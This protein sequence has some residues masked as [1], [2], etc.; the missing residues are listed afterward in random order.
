MKKF[1]LALQ[2]LTILSIRINLKIKEQDFGQSL[3]YFPIVGFLIGLVLAA[4]AACLRF[5]PDLVTGACVLISSIIITGGIHLDGFADTCDGLYGRR[6]QEE[7]LKIMRDSRAGV[8]GV[9][10][11]T[12]LLLLKFTLIVSIPQDFLGK[13]LILMATFSRWSQGLAC[14]VSKYARSEGK[15]KFFIEYARKKDVIIGGLFTLVLFLLMAKVNGVLIFASAILCAS[16]FIQYAKR[17][18][19][20]MTGDTI[21]ATSEIAEVAV[22]FFGLIL[23]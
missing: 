2:F 13:S 16:L 17:K 10:G 21:G 15:A 6:T 14:L 5:L 22:L 11:V 7:I 20:G 1:L 18:L 23:L 4:L 9:I 19:G 3:F 8:M 12:C